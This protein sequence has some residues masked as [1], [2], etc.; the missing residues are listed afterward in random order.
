MYYVQHRDIK[1]QLVKYL[2]MM[3]KMYTSWLNEGLEFVALT[4]SNS[5]EVHEQYP[6]NNENYPIL[7]I[8]GVGG[9]EDDW[10]IDSH[11]TTGFKFLQIGQAARDYSVLGSSDVVAF[12]VKSKINNFKVRTV[13]VGIK[14][15]DQSSDYDLAMTLM[16]SSAGSPTT[17]IASGSISSYDLNTSRVSD[18]VFTELIPEV[19]LQSNEAYFVKLNLTNGNYGSYYLL[20]DNAPTSRTS[21][22]RT[23]VSGSSV[24]SVVSGSTP[25]AAIQGPMNKFLGGG[26]NASFSIYI[27][28]KDL[29]SAQKIS[30]LTFVYLKLLR[31]VGLRRTEMM[32]FPTTTRTEFI[33]MSNEARMGLH[34]VRV[35]KGSEA[36]RERGNDRIFSIPLNVECY[37]MWSEEFELPTLLDIDNEITNF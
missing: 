16:S 14:L 24:W 1:K 37:G 20:E 11:I 19:T 34:I 4:D 2:R 28:A 35:D 21:F 3:F 31:H 5:P 30:E 26:I 17:E 25:L 22:P 13:G 29:A 12:G 23:A 36:V 32:D 33:R 10:A 15:T 7:V 9:S 6:W 18:F 27:E 8:G